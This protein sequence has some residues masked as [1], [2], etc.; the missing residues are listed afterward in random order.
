M[1]NISTTHTLREIGV[2]C[3]VWSWSGSVVQSKQEFQNKH[4]L[5]E[6]RE[7]KIIEIIS[8]LM[9]RTALKELEI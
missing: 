6:I 4:L 1:R 5:H 9:L 7:D 3:S 2:Q 8:N